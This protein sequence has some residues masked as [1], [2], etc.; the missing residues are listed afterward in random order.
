MK[1][2]LSIMLAVMMLVSLFAA[3]VS[4]SVATYEG[5]EVKTILAESANVKS[6]MPYIRNK[7]A[8]ADATRA[9]SSF[10]T[11][12][13]GEDANEVAILKY[14]AEGQEWLFGSNQS[15][16]APYEKLVFTFDVN[17]V[18]C[19]SGLQVGFNTGAAT[20]SFVISPAT[21]M[22]AQMTPYGT[23]N[24]QVEDSD[25]LNL[26]QWYNFRVTVDKSVFAA[27][28]AVDETVRRNAMTIEWK[29]A[30]DEKF[31]I[32]PY[33][34]GGYYGY[35]L[36]ARA[37]AI[38]PSW[39]QTGV[40]I[41]PNANSYMVCVDA[42]GNSLKENVEYHID[43]VKL[44]GRMPK[45]VYPSTGILVAEDFEGT[46]PKFIG[47]QGTLV[48]NEE[49]KY[50]DMYL[51]TPVTEKANTTYG[52]SGTVNFT[53]LPQ[54]FVLTADICMAEDNT[55]PFLFEYFTDTLGVTDADGKLLAGYAHNM[56]IE[57]TDVVAGT[58][59]TA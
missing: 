46:S 25:S 22:G 28:A 58:W 35:K 19:A 15:T 27:A 3:S 45:V 32:M 55:Q 42:E 30:E 18:N 40:A 53:S 6:A 10:A 16:L 11:V 20:T 39:T 54:N 9:V 1:K 2:V 26:N 34:I 31:A 48:G 4:A 49:N 17:V 7:V 13:E 29:K 5:Y 43:N 59:Y 56:K 33:I 36:G 57:A 44:I 23:A 41:S 8:P 21:F 37:D 38:M 51:S 24:A 14:S 47:G 12:G 50:M 52:S